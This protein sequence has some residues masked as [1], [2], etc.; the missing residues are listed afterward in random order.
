MSELERHQF[1]K[2]FTAKH[3]SKEAAQI[4]DG[5]LEQFHAPW[6]NAMKKS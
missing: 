5:L 3:L 1:V 6:K 2:N 4:D